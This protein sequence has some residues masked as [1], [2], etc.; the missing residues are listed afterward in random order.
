MSTK[1]I[2][3]EILFNG[4]LDTDSDEKF[5]PQ[6]DYVDALNMIKVED[7][8][9]G[10]M[11][12]IKGNE[13]VYTN[14]NLGYSEYL[15]GWAFYKKNESVILFMY[16][17]DL[18]A[19]YT[20][21]YKI[22]EYNPQ[23]E[24]VHELVNNSILNFRNPTLTDY[25]ISAKILDDWVQWTD[26]VNEPRLINIQDVKDNNPTINVAYLN[27]I[28]SPPL[29]AP[30]FTYGR[31]VDVQNN[32]IAKSLFQFRSQ[33]VLDDY[34][35]TIWSPTSGLAVNDA[36]SL[37]PSA[38]DESLA[39]NFLYIKINSGGQQVKYINIAAKTSP[40]GSWF[41]IVQ[42]DVENPQEVYSKSGDTYTLVTTALSQDTDYYY[43]YLNDAEYASLD[44]FRVDLPYDNVPEKSETTTSIGD[45]RFVLGGNTEGKEIVD[46]DVTLTAEYGDKNDYVKY[47][48]ATFSGSDDGTDTTITYTFDFAALGITEAFAGDKIEFDWALDVTL[49]PLSTERMTCNDIILFVGT[50]NSAADII[51]YVVSENP[52]VVSNADTEN[53]T[54]I[55]N[56]LVFTFVYNS[57]LYVSKD[58][59]RNSTFFKSQGIELSHKRGQPHNYAMIYYDDY[60][61]KSP[62]LPI[63]DSVYIDILGNVASNERGVA[64][65]K[66]SISHSAPT[67]ASYYRFAYAYESPSLLQCICTDVSVFEDYNQEIDLNNLALQIKS[68]SELLDVTT[69]NVLNYTFEKGDRLRVI[70]Y[71]ATNAY[72]SAPD[73]RLETSYKNF[74]ILEVKDTINDGSNDIA[75]LWVVLKPIDE[76]GY[77]YSDTGVN[78][79]FYNA[80]VEVYKDF[81]DQEEVI[82]YEVGELGTCS[83]G[84]HTPDTDITLAGG[85][86]WFRTRTLY[87]NNGVSV[88]NEVNEFVE[89]PYASD[90]ISI[91]SVGYGRPNVEFKESR[92]EYKNT[93]K[94]SGKFFQDTKIN[95]LSTYDI[96]N[97]DGSL[98]Y[99]DVSDTYGKVKGLEELGNSLV[100][101]CEEKV[102]SS[103]VGATEY[104]DTSGNV[105]VV[106]STDVLGYLR[107]HAERYGTFLKESIINTGKYIYFFDLFNGV[108]IRKAVN[109]LFPIS[110]TVF[111]EKGAYDY[112]MRSFFKSL[113]NQLID[114]LFANTGSASI[115]DYLGDYQNIKVYTGFDPYYENIYMTFVDRINNSNN[116]SLIFN[117]PSN[118][119]MTKYTGFIS[120]D[121]NKR[122]TFYP[123]TK[124]ELFSFLEGGA[125]LGVLYRQNS[126]TSDRCNLYGE[127][128]SS[129]IQ[130]VS[131]KAFNMNKVFNSIGIHT[132]SEYIVD[133]IEI[134]PTINNVNGMYSKIPSSYFIYEEGI[135]KC[136]FF[137]NMKTRSST[138]NNYDLH[139]G[140]ELRGKVL[141]IKMTNNS[142]SKIELFKVD[143]NSE[144]SR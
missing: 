98:P 35:S 40:T 68:I 52:V 17:E 27:T 62:A 12:N 96:I 56:T 11:V 36:I 103:F 31:D 3:E 119:W 127:A 101:I 81:P 70:R 39:D 34:R 6:G 130:F 133:P 80:F 128:Q 49:N 106:K 65:V 59:E 111:H 144:L 46:V 118:R 19:P 47:M 72:E 71:G 90:T 84:T 134:A 104:T 50:L 14:S 32:N 95:A 23:T 69:G 99:K 58:R 60:G 74:E 10:V 76:V 75:G 21:L 44:T 8:Q 29:F 66:A 87:Y 24:V 126:S 97:S 142:T 43:K 108:V 38:Y 110:G 121:V 86:V 120:G 15:C 55:G 83:N 129:Y 114:S 9:A 2:N 123:F 141:K 33:Y 93:V 57:N 67:W 73:N 140:D 7:S 42:I 138:A 16:A 105:N 125:L 82:Y 64:Q 48:S 88:D 102:L 132:D 22:L 54:R 28:K 107:P 91:K 122:A 63:T 18:S 109:G 37:S 85:D 131:H 25:F 124:N 116:I 117:E 4:G 13:S 26:G 94:W 79:K 53:I 100:V 112:K 137:R 1:I 139:N 45:N 113:S 61:R 89:D 135:Q 20:D 136:N 41:K 92:S 143:L 77:S 115:S 78:S 5:I 30:E 51:D